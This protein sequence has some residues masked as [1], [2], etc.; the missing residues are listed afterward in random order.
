MGHWIVIWLILMF[1]QAAVM[2]NFLLVLLF[3]P[4][5]AVVRD[6]NILNKNPTN[7]V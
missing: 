4:S 3:K 1:Q 7:Q 6:K 2:C 5:K